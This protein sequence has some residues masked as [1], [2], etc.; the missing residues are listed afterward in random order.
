MIEPHPSKVGNIV[1]DSGVLCVRGDLIGEEGLYGGDTGGRDCAVAV[2]MVT[3][4][5]GRF[6]GKD[7]VTSSGTHYTVKTI[8]S[9]R[10]NENVKLDLT[11]QSAFRDI[12]PRT[13][14]CRRFLP[15]SGLP[16]NLG[17]LTD[18]STKKYHSPMAEIPPSTSDPSERS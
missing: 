6:S 9:R 5:E 16:S 13:V 14:P 1:H 17:I 2:E 15:H 3:G 11:R 7:V 10:E 4:N 8:V 12:H 18:C